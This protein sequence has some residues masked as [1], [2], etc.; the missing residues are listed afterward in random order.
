MSKPRDAD[1]ERESVLMSRVGAADVRAFEHDGT[2]AD[3]PEGVLQQ[4][5]IRLQLR[6]A[7]SALPIE[8]RTVPHLV[9]CQGCGCREAAEIMCC[10]TDAVKTRAFYVRRKLSNGLLGM[11]AGA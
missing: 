7:L 1:D 8:Q 9:Y 5:E 6:R 11:R 10:P 2:Y 4:S 3:L